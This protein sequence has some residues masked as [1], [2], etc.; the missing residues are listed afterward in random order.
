MLAKRG[1]VSSAQGGLGVCTF[2]KCDLPFQFP[3]GSK[4]PKGRKGQCNKGDVRV[5]IDLLKFVISGW[6]EIF[7]SKSS[8]AIVT[9]EDLGKFFGL[10][11]IFASGSFSPENFHGVLFALKACHFRLLRILIDF[12]DTGIQSLRPDGEITVCG[13]AKSDAVSIVGGV[14][15]ISGIFYDVGRIL[16]DCSI[17][18]FNIFCSQRTDIIFPPPDV[19]SP[20]LVSVLFLLQ[21]EVCTGLNLN[22]KERFV[23]SL[24]TIPSETVIGIDTSTESIELVLA[25]EQKSHCVAVHRSTLVGP[26]LNFSKPFGHTTKPFESLLAR[27]FVDRLEMAVEEI[28]VEEID[29]KG[30]IFEVDFCIPIGQKT[31][32][33]PVSADA[34]FKI[35][36]KCFIFSCD[37]SVHFSS[38]Q[39]S[40][41]MCL[42]PSADDFLA[43]A[44]IP[45]KRGKTESPP[46]GRGRS[47]KKTKKTTRVVTIEPQGG[48][49][50]EVLEFSRYLDGRM[51][52]EVA[53]KLLPEDKFIFVDIPTVDTT[54]MVIKECIHHSF[55]SV[56]EREEVQQFLSSLGEGD[57]GGEF[58]RFLEGFD[59]SLEFPAADKVVIQLKFTFSGKV[60]LPFDDMRDK[61]VF[62]QLAT[63][64]RDWGFEVM[65][66]G[67]LAISCP[68][69]VEGQVTL[70]SALNHAFNGVAE[71]VG[72]PLLVCP[73]VSKVLE[74][75]EV[76][77]V[78]EIPEEE[79]KEKGEEE[80]STE[81]R[82]DGDTDIED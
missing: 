19:L 68:P 77:E 20:F 59:F 62:T 50:I 12:P 81:P 11:R 71:R 37:G 32:F 27:S 4:S 26:F 16:S 46:P 49:T 24:S 55:I 82:S 3:K 34:L 64:Y 7:E 54:S 9:Y 47:G 74:I 30:P 80:T 66:D 63:S 8:G 72:K 73:E 57:R 28:D 58:K 43:R 69:P 48:P 39:A 10:W 13:Y 2:V 5:E 56:R 44:V 65:E 79:Q 33:L 36:G 1:V 41:G 6:P 22:F 51:R 78:L 35:G 40:E 18:L 14:D 67:K 60:S 17:G 53:R 76:L 52:R 29:V 75:S 42:S 15:T 61:G 23:T 38:S 70:Q 31:F 25:N 21:N 45:K